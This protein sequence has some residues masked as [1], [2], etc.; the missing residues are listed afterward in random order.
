MDGKI[1]YTLLFSDDTTQKLTIGTYDGELFNSS[2][3]T[4]IKNNVKAFNAGIDSDTS[5]I[6]LSKYGGS[7]VGISKAKAI[8]TETNII[9]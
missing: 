9:F 8:V 6:A 1:E 3:L 2:F 5:A 4:G 7:W